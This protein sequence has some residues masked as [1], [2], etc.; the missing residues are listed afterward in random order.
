MKVLI[1]ANVLIS[2]L[3]KEGLLDVIVWVLA[4]AEF[5]VKKTQVVLC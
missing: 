4:Q 3:L 1:D 2:A 5:Y